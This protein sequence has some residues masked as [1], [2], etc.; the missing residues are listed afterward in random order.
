MKTALDQIIKK[1]ESTNIK[2]ESEDQNKTWKR[3]KNECVKKMVDPLP[4]NNP[5]NPD[6]VLFKYFYDIFENSDV[7]LI[8]LTISD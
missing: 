2:F 4:L 8:F 6:K 3:I 7:V 5:P 1:F